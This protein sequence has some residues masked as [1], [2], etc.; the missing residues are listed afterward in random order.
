MVTRYGVPCRGIEVVSTTSK[1]ILPV[2][3]TGTPPVGLG[4][5]PPLHLKAGDTMAPGLDG[6]GEQRQRVMPFSL[7]RL[8]GRVAGPLGPSL[9]PVTRL[10]RPVRST[11]APG[12]ETWR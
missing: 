12:R 10:R 11:P 4:M 8:T 5:K 9:A 2:D 3:I 1:M 6:L 7:E